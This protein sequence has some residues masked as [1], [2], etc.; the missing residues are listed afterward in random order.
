MGHGPHVLPEGSDRRRCG[1]AGWIQ[2]VLDAGQTAAVETFTLY[3]ALRP[4]ATLDDAAVDGLGAVVR[5]GDGDLRL[6]REPGRGLLRVSTE[7]AAED[8]DAALE[9]GHALGAETLAECPGMLLEV[10]ALGDDDSLVWR[11]VP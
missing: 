7:C 6:W 3:V 2:A 10:A 11:A 5:P 8:L 4:E 9:M 1:D